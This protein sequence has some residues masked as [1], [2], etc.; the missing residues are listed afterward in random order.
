L[1]LL[2][3]PMNAPVPEDKDLPLRED[4]RLLGRVL[5]D[6]LRAQTGEAG[7]DRIEAI[8]QTAVQ[9][10]RA[11][12]DEA[13]AARD[14]LSGLLNPLPI[15]DVLHVVRAF[16][17]FSHLANIAEDVHHNRRRRAHAAAGAP[18]RAGSVAHALERLSAAQVPER[19]IQEWLDRALVCPVLTAHP[20]EVQRKSILDTEREIARLL[21]W[22]DRTALT[23][24]ERTAFD[25]ELRTQVLGLWQTA[26][27]RLN[28]LAVRD[29]IENGL[30]YYR[31]TFLAELPR[32]YRRLEAEL[33]KAYPGMRVPSFFRT[34]SWIG[35]D[36]DGNPFV[37][38][39]TLDYAVRAHA[40][41]AFEHYLE[42][43]NCLGAELSLSTRLIK[44]SAG[45]MT[46]AGAAHD[47]N[48]HRS[49]EPYRQALSG[50]YARL[51]ATSRALAHHAPARAPHASGEAYESP[52]AFGA[53]LDVIA[54]SLAGHGASDLAV[55]RLD[56]LRRAVDVFGFHLASLD[57]RQNSDV[58][59][60]VVGE[61][62]A[63]AGVTRDYAALDEDERVR[64]LTQELSSP[65][66]LHSPYRVLSDRAASELAI[67]RT[68]ADTH[69]RFGPR[70]LPHYVISKCQ[71]ASD[72]LEVAV[73]LKEVGLLRDDRLAMAIV[74][75][76]ET[77]ADLGRCGAVMAETFSIPRYRALVAGQGDWQE[78]MIGYSD[79][80]KDGG[81]LTANWALYC[82]ER[83]LV[84][85]FAQERVQLRLFH[86]R[87][88]TVGRGGGP[89]YDAILAQPVGTAQSGLR[90]TEQGEIIASKYSDPE[91][92]RRNLETL[93]AAALEAGLL[94]SERI[95]ERASVYH[96]ALDTLSPH[97]HRAYRGL[98]YETPGFVD[99]FR[100]STPDSPE[101]PSST[102]A[103]GRRH[104]PLRR[105]SRTCAPFPGSSAGAMPPDAARLVRLRHG[106]RG[107][108]GR[109]QDGLAA[110]VRDARA[111]AVL[112]QRAVEHG[113]GARQDR[114]RGRLALRGARSRRGAALVHL[115]PH[116]GRAPAHRALD[117]RDHA[118]EDAP[119]RQS[120]ARAQH[121]QTA[122]RTST[123]STI[124]S[125]AAAALSRRADGR[126]TRRAIHLTIN[127]LAA[128]LRTAGS[129]ATARRPLASGRAQ[130]ARDPKRFDT[131][132][133]PVRAPHGM[134]DTVLD[135]SAGP[136]DVPSGHSDALDDPRQPP[137]VLLVHACAP[138]R[139][140][141]CRLPMQRSPARW[142][143]SP[144]MPTTSN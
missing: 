90:M 65:R 142:I 72:L 86:G 116:R 1:L 37:T 27:L 112:P 35:G 18:P 40:T 74:P 140:R 54:A 144:R 92:G 5:G 2:H 131:V 136:G 127:G 99:Y 133:H 56:P 88:G 26:M 96:A 94:D 106:G 36:R 9:F 15:A 85:R 66:L 34:G 52:A 125:R 119:R 113:D 16:S 33:A 117:A 143:C 10:R 21:V 93:V 103:A 137:D 141:I 61:L 108:A 50:I 24:D 42:E 64:L 78:V 73:L 128:G 121:P 63:A 3:Y 46:L 41:L 68:A 122:F 51:A 76:F 69:A 77:I 80:N 67:L 126:A 115:Q 124:C 83:T 111:L 138:T 107:M 120:H 89:S 139:S 17:Y 130:H 81:Y 55:R 13:E 39:E 43:V 20:T 102:S 38:A 62:L 110:A 97:A 28:R 109:E 32:L 19:G 71:S 105:R 60:T 59:E 118:A 91:L 135:A 87:G 8:R 104:A 57:L 79:S 95:G 11:T 49:D 7:F 44:P 22:R 53:D 101:S 132:D 100:A 114:S 6:V 14:T 70:A 12:E 48:P 75:L 84:Q 4:T 123:R 23:P 82:A 58:H 31:Y 129:K 45:L 47:P 25:R 30:S 134:C 98:V 29:E